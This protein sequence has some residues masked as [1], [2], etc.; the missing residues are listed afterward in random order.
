MLRQSRLPYLGQMVG[1]SFYRFRAK[2][3]ADARWREWPHLLLAIGVVQAAYWLLIAPA[4]YPVPRPAEQFAIERVE[5][6]QL[7]TAG[8]AGLSQASFEKTALPVDLCCESA[9]YAFR[10]TFQVDTVPADGLGEVSHAHADNVF[11]Y[12]NG[13]LAFGRGSVEPGLSTMHS[14]AERPVRRIPPALLREGTNTITYVA[15]AG[16]G[17][18]G[19]Y[20]HDPVIGPYKPVY[21]TQQMQAFLRDEY[22]VASVTIGL[23]VGLIALLGWLRSGRN[24]FLFWMGMLSG[25]WGLSL[26]MM[27]TDAPPLAAG[28]WIHLNSVVGMVIPL[29][30]VNLANNWGPRSIP[31]LLP[32]S[33]AIWVAAITA[34]SILIAERGMGGPAE[35]VLFA[36]TALY[37]FIYSA[38]IVW[39]L[40]AIGRERH[41]EA[42]VF[43]LLATIA[44]AMA[45][46]QIF[47]T[48][49]GMPTNYAVPILLLALVAAFV[50][51]NIRLF[52][53][54]ED[55][56]GLL[57]VKLDER[58]A[59]LG[60][61]HAR[62]K[63]LLRE[64]AHQEER[65]RIMADMHDGMG[66]NLM[67]ML[68]S[69]RRGNAEPEAVAR[70]L[71]SA[72]DEMR[73]MIDSM[74]SVGESLGAAL[75]LFRER[76][77]SRVTDAGFA[78]AWH[79][80]SDTTLP[81]LQPRPVL[82]VFRVLQEAVTNALKHSDGD[83]ITVDVA[84]RSIAVRDNGSS[85]GKVRAGGRGLENMA[86]RAEMI[87][88]EFTL[89][90]ECDWTVARIQLP[91][92]T[93]GDKTDG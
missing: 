74:D 90:R 52:R 78:F 63:T 85:V 19:I 1:I 31:R 29:A 14:Y 81:L 62:E 5:I 33:L 27:M 88:G 61:A 23:S 22:L 40:P 6:A 39:N 3:G 37:A 92:S 4:F 68:L 57:K 65:R 32:A 45:V 79:Q 8:A 82:Q 30:G 41:W 72:I 21:E 20:V 50:A 28:P 48:G 16:A 73:L 70:G 76:A 34:S 17:G 11:T 80:P 24:P 49:T 25:S 56:A 89:Q 12:V 86:A 18:H 44:V 38:L 42:A 64:Q 36:T 43:L 46:W 51:R 58:T 60:A 47:G 53:S 87:G 67:S 66:S 83:T 35:W 77:Q 9:L 10:L 7:E 13:E 55:I 93:L 2:V 15:A 91:D 69:A 71:Q 54:A 75:V 84:S 59:E 26:L